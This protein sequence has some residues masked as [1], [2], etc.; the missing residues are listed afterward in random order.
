MFDFYDAV[1]RND[2][3]Q[4]YRHAFLIIVADIKKSLWQVRLQLHDLADY[5]LVA[6]GQNTPETISALT[7][8]TG[9]WEHDALPLLALLIENPHTEDN[10]RRHAM[11]WRDKIKSKVNNGDE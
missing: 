2:S 9:K 5:A 11:V 6:K 3:L 7:R 10:I 8:L 4:H 1:L